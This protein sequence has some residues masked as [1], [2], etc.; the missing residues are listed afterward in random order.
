MTEDEPGRSPAR[1]TP[2]PRPAT[3]RIGETMTEP[4]PSLAAVS[5]TARGMALIRA[6]SAS[7][8]VDLMFAH[9]ATRSGASNQ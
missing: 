4:H 6:P 1:D 9:G 5:K 8:G 3:A 2:T 7:A